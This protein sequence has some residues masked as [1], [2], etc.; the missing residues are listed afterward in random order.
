MIKRLLLLIAIITSISSQAQTF[1]Y[2][3]AST[4]NEGEFPVDKDT[5]IYM[6]H[7]DRLVKTD[8][9]FNV[10]WAFTYA[11]MKFNRLLLSKTGSIY[12]VSQSGYIGNVY[13]GKLNSDGSFAWAKD[14]SAINAVVS[15]TANVSYSLQCS[16]IL[17]DRNNHLVVTG[18]EKTYWPPGSTGFILKLDTNGTPLK[19]KC[20][21]SG[22]LATQQHNLSLVN[23]SLGYY[24]LIACGYSGMGPSSII[25]CHSYND[26]T[27]VFLYTRNF[28][29]NSGPAF[30]LMRSKNGRN[31]YLL[32]TYISSVGSAEFN[33]FKYKLNNQFVWRNKTTN[34]LGMP[35]YANTNGVAESNS[36]ELINS[37]NTLNYYSYFYTTGCFVVDSNG[38]SNTNG[39]TMLNNY[40]VSWTQSSANTHVSSNRPQSLYSDKYYFDV[41][42]TN[43]PVNPLT[44]Q[45]FSSASSFSCASS[46][47]CA[48]SNATP[49]VYGS[50]PIN[51][52]IVPITSYTI[53]NYTQ[54]ANP[55]SYSINPNYCLVMNSEEKLDKGKTIISPNPA[56]SKIVIHSNE[57]VESVE[58]YD[59]SGKL[60]STHSNSNEIDVSGLTQGMYFLRMNFGNEIVTKKFIKN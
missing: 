11:P 17:L 35:Q 51:P 16:S 22:S 52:S 59:I 8:K 45:R 1:P 32:T 41:L 40:F 44:I 58:V 57:K 13:F 3:N 24:K 18:S 34:A 19:F 50:V 23:D 53:N 2:L 38:I 46:A 54:W 49:I 28:N 10:I 7:G 31:F 20:F 37:F 25:T 42:A 15:G 33:I 14:I 47:T 56:H 9:N 26:N 12:F 29:S 55:I 21:K 5:N 27:D 48:Y 6:F 39:F 36:G 43:Y 4:G 60:I 30:N